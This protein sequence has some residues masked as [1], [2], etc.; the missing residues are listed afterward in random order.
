VAGSL[1]EALCRTVELK[2][3]KTH[4]HPHTKRWWTEDLTKLAGE[5]KQLHITAHRYRALPEHAVH[6]QVHKKENT[7]S[8]EI[9]RT[10]EDHWKNWLNDM[11]GTVI[12][13]AHKY[14][15]NPGRDGGKTQIP[16]LHVTNPDGQFSYATTNEE[17]SETLTQALFPPPP[18]ETTVPTD[19]LYPEL[20]EHWTEITKEQ[21]MQAINNLSPYKAPGPDG[22]ANIVFQRCQILVNYLL[23]I[24]NAAINLRTY[25]HL[26][27]CQHPHPF[28]SHRNVTICHWCHMDS[29][30]RI[31]TPLWQL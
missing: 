2:V 24:F 16:T 20:A 1:D 23:P 14:I 12:W 29:V 3:P 15:S 8:K 30:V 27:C 5:L 9:R 6:T 17:K 10:K 13:I 25:Y 18:D 7:L 4:P 28:G 21:L 19:Y 26:H 31:V 22:I 11:A